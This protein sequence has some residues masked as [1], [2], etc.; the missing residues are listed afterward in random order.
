MK[1][2]SQSS[3]FGTPSTTHETQQP[4]AYS[5]LFLSLL[6][7]FVNNTGVQLRAVLGI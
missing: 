3:F 7:S 4:L 6:K 2:N 5:E 1:L